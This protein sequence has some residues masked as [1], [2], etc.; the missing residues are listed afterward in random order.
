[1]KKKPSEVDDLM[2]QHAGEGVSDLP[3]DLPSWHDF[4]F[5]EWDWVDAL[6][7]IDKDKNPQPLIKLLAR[8]RVPDRAMPL[9]ADFLQKKLGPPPPGPPSYLYKTSDKDMAYLVAFPMVQELVDSGVPVKEAAK[10]VVATYSSLPLTAKSLAG[11]YSGRSS[12]G[13]KI[14]KRMRDRDSA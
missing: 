11:V 3:S 1:M 6:H 5:P 12:H 2:E 8:E 7:A 13:R 4:S 10:R 14:R 9:V